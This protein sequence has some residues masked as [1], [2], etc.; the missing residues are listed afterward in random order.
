MLL[1]KEQ[2]LLERDQ[3]VQVLREEVSCLCSPWF[4][5]AHVIVSASRGLHMAEHIQIHEMQLPLSLCR[6]L[7]CFAQT[8]AH[9]PRQTK[10]AMLGAA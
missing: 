9:D 3:T 4:P 6:C 8:A 2:E 1:G 7:H 10:Q 5:K